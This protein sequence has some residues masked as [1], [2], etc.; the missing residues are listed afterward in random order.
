MFRCKVVGLKRFQGVMDGKSI[1]SG[2][3]FIEVR[4]DDSRNGEK[5]FSKGLAFEEIRLPSSELVR[6]IEHTPLPA[7]FDVETERVSNGR[8]SRELVI[9]LRPVDVVKPAAAKAA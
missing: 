1:D 9:D 4:L 2:K 6:R 3:I 8:E 7:Y 5:Q